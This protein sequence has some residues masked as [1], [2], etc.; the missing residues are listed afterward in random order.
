MINFSLGLAYIHYALKRQSSNRQ[1]LLLQGQSF[2]SKYAEIEGQRPPDQPSSS[3]SSS[4]SSSLSGS[5]ASYY[6]IGRVFHLLG[7]AYLAVEYYAKA[8]EIVDRT[9]P[10]GDI[11]VMTAANYVSLLMTVRNKGLAME[12]T[13]RRLIL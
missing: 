6:N 13:K 11:A 5:A 4:S 3:S 1:Y 12:I 7:I 2:L 10:R 9:D 8:L